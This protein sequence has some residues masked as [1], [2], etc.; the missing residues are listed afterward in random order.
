[1]A[2][3]GQLHDPSVLTPGEEKR[4]EFQNLQRGF[5]QETNLLRDRRLPLRLNGILPSSGLLRGVRWFDMD[6]SKLSIGPIFKGKT[7]F[8]DLPFKMGQ[9]DSPE[10]S[11]PNHLTPCVTTGERRI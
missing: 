10:T 3:S 11:V 6:V 2:V 1:M 5:G 7:S 8:T 4:L 9:I